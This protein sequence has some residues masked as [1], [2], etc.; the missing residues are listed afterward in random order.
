MA[1][2]ISGTIGCS[3]WGICTRRMGT[4][5]QEPLR[6]CIVA[7]NASFRF[8]GEASLPLHYYS[9]LRARGLEAWLIVH[10]R[11]RRGTGSAFPERE[12]RIRFIPD[13]WFHKMIWRL[14]AYLP[15]RI[16]EATLG[17][18]MVLVN[19][20]IQRQMVRALIATIT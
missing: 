20:W 4:S 7:E 8:G 12:G 19:Q 11:T 16:A 5:N 17:T 10:G 13:K 3:K 6:V 14:N 9:R 18:L 1:K 2:E 15:P